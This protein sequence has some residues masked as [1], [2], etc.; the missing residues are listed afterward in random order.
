[1]KLP[2][3]DKQ[4]QQQQGTKRPAAAAAGG[5]N[6]QQQDGRAAK[7]LKT[8]IREAVCP[9]WGRPYADQLNDKMTTVNNTLRSLSEKVSVFM[10]QCGGWLLFRQIADA[11]PT[12]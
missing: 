3:G 4:Q 1:M 5:S 10:L 9:W 2:G 6:E 12:F 11:V 7:Q 8:D